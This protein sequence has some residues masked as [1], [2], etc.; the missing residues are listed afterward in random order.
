PGRA[1]ILKDSEKRGLFVIVADATNDGQDDI[2][3]SKYQ[4]RT[5]GFSHISLTIL[6]QG[7]ADFEPV[8]ELT[9]PGTGWE[10]FQILDLNRD[11]K[12]ELVLATQN[13]VA[14]RQ[15]D[16][17]LDDFRLE[18]ILIELYPGVAGQR[19]WIEAP[20]GRQ[21]QMFH[22]VTE[23]QRA[24]KSSLLN[25][26]IVFDVPAEVMARIAQAKL[27][28]PDELNVDSYL[29]TRFVLSS[30]DLHQNRII[31]LAAEKGAMYRSMFMISIKPAEKQYLILN[32]DAGCFLLP[33]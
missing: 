22:L 30:A 13:A 11:G 14:F 28:A 17:L 25:S 4:G 12:N 6:S 10:G 5:E 27:L 7:D 21:T 2:I 24:Q 26:I 18:S 15:F 1:P 29:N 20:N 3:F 8:I 31:P 33:D 9:S 23:F 16:P 19:L 32:T